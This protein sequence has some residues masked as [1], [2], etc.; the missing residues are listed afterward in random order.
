MAILPRPAPTRP[1]PCGYSPP[2]RGGGAVTG[3]KNCP[4]TRGGAIPSPSP[5]A[6]SDFF[7]PSLPHAAAHQPPL[8]SPSRRQPPASL[9]LSRSSSLIH[10][11]AAP[12]SVTPQILSVTPQILAQSR[13]RSRRRS[14]LSRRRSSLSHAVDPRSVTPQISRS[15]LSHA[16]ALHYNPILGAGRGDAGRSGSGAGRDKLPR[17]P[18]RGGVGYWLYKCGAGSGHPLSGPDPP[19]CHI[20]VYIRHK[21][22]EM[23][24]FWLNLVGTKC[25]QTLLWVIQL[26][27]SVGGDTFFF[28]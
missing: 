25:G 15:S 27:Q 3:Y 8:H 17:P 4:D 13:R 10:A 6:A 19:R 20:L 16:A 7:L 23:T 2:R 12:R 21:Y 26:E 18:G 11:A 1:D 14:S 5:P 22:S 9:T 28:C 24:L